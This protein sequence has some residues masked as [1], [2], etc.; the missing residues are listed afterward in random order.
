MSM[1]NFLRTISCA[2]L[3]I[4]FTASGANSYDNL[5]I[6][7]DSYS[8]RGNAHLSSNGFVVPAA[9]GF[10]DGRWSNGPM[11]TEHLASGLGL[12]EPTPGF[13]TTFS[14]GNNLAVGGAKTGT[15]SS[16]GPAWEGNGLASQVAGFGNFYSNPATNGS[17]LFVVFAGANDIVDVDFFNPNS[18]GTI[19]DASM[20][21]IDAAIRSLYNLG[22]R[23][24][25]MPNL[26]GHTVLGDTNPFPQNQTAFANAFNPEL[27]ATINT[28]RT[29]LADAEIIGVDFQG[30]FQDILNNPGSFGI[31]NTSDPCLD[32][33]A[34]FS[35]LGSCGGAANDYL[36]FDTVH[37]TAT[38]HAALG[39]A[40]LAAIQPVPVPA[41]LP[42]LV[43]AIFSLSWFRR[44]RQS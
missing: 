41:A 12:P 33:S 42:L 38:A 10:L 34:S 5:W 3:A 9:H 14:V 27:N 36:L 13:N 24:F 2:L 43:S 8:D 1:K 31:T 29:D 22:A 15:G 18:L 35:L 17:A 40:A 4:S 37:P 30:V 28:L 21:N 26:P 6:L 7:G 16:L 11:W 32:Y 25:L 23:S 19:I 44:R 39:A 20:A